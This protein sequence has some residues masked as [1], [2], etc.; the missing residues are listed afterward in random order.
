MTFRTVVLREW[1][2]VLSVLLGLVGILGAGMAYHAQ[3]GR[4]A[5]EIAHVR[6]MSRI[7]SE[8]QDMLRKL[9]TNPKARPLSFD[10]CAGSELVRA[11][12]ANGIDLPKQDFEVRCETASHK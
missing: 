5:E 11:L 4:D 1:M 9:L 3:E 7:V 12:R 6:D 2:W 10:A 8:N